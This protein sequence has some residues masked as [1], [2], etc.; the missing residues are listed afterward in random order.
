[1]TFPYN[2][3]KDVLTERSESVV[4][5]EMNEKRIFIIDDNRFFLESL[6]FILNRQ[7]DMKVVGAHHCAQGALQLIDTA[8]PDVIILD[9]R[10]PDSDGIT[11]LQGIKSHFEI[12]VIMLTMYEEHKDRAIKNGAYAYLVKG[13]GLDLLYQTIRKATVVVVNS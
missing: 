11:L 1:M 8:K 13:G 6:I 10:L 4:G 9:M 5:T 12:P 3:A 7:N 2:F